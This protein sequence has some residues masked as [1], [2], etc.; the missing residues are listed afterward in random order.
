MNTEDDT[1]RILCRLSFFE[2]RNIHREWFFDRNDKRYWVTIL[3][4]HGWN[5][6]DWWDECRKYADRR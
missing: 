1:F 4:D 5:S 2:M 6:K 3:K